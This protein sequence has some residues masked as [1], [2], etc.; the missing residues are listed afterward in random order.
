[1]TRPNKEYREN[2]SR[3]VYVTGE[4][5]QVLVERLT[6]EIMR[7]R[8]ESADPITA[9]ID[10]YGGDIQPA[11]I[12][13]NLV[14]SPNQDGQRP[15]LITVATGTAASAAADLLTL[16]DY[17]IAYP[18]AQII[19]HGTKRAAPTGL[20]VE[21]ASSIAQ[22]LQQANEMFAARLATKAFDRFIIRLMLFKNEFQSYAADVQAS[23]NIVP[24][25]QA[26]CKR[27]SSDAS[28]LVK[29]A[30]LMQRDIKNLSNAVNRHLK[31]LKR[32]REPSGFE[33]EVLK[34]ILQHSA[35]EFA[36]K[37]RL[38]SQ[39]GLFEVEAQ[40]RILWDFHFGGHQQLVERWVNTYG[41]NFLPADEA[42]VYDAFPPDKTNAK[43]EWLKERTNQKI[44]F[45][46]YFTVS[47]CRMLQTADFRLT[48]EDAY[49]LGLVNEI[50]GRSDDLPNERILIEAEPF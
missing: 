47:L 12:I 11:E 23:P 18:H 32:K 33:M 24:L 8:H 39:G 7:L 22:S 16:G 26:M 4:I 28:R 44:R 45:L 36:K 41:R 48:P 13:R 46:W 20:T 43:A 40:F 34:G 49:W 5:R 25:I 35:R 50:T 14:Q 15:R 9:Y 21:A 30:A 27:L 31:R 6:P 3:A 37:N 19:Y 1:M 29:Q 17:A 10:S 2:S 38:L 42:K